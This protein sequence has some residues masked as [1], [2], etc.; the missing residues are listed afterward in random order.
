M[1]LPAYCDACGHDY[2]LAESCKTRLNLLDPL[3]PA[4]F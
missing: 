4:K 3:E 1:A 2:L